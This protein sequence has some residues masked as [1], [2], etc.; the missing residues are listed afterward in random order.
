MEAQ[1]NGAVELQKQTRGAAEG[2]MNWP[3]LLLS[4][5]AQAETNANTKANANANANANTNANANA[6]ANT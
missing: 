1:W 5:G 4:P 6:N 3:L 2:Q